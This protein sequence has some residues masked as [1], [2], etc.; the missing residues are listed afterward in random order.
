M[1][2]VDTTGEET[3]SSKV[4]SLYKDPETPRPKTS[5]RVPSPT[6]QQYT[7]YI[8]S[9]TSKKRNDAS[10]RCASK[11]ELKHKLLSIGSRIVGF[12]REEKGKSELVEWERTLVAIVSRNL[13]QRE[14]VPDR[15]NANPPWMNTET[16]HK[17]LRSVANKLWISPKGTTNTLFFLHTHMHTHTHIHIQHRC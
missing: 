15:L 13:V 17:I 12:L 7:D 9:P 11:D 3:K 5:R 14:D 4:K 8:P 16:Y 1:L 2:R 10:S 6:I